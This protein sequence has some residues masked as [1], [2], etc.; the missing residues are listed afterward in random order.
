MTA[1][2][3]TY[4]ERERYLTPKCKVFSVKVE[5][6]ILQGSYDGTPDPYGDDDE[7]PLDPLT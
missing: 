5:S 7:N 6:A 3:K 2:L 4:D 1:I